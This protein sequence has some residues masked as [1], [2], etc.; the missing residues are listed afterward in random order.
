MFLTKGAC[1]GPRRSP[2]TLYCWMTHRTGTPQAASSG[3]SPATEEEGRGRAHT[4]SRGRGGPGPHGG[5][6]GALPRARSS[7]AGGP[8]RPRQWREPRAPPLS[9][10]PVGP[11]AGR[12]RAVSCCPET[13]PTWPVSAAT[14]A[15]S[16]CSW[17][18]PGV[19]WAQP[20]EGPPLPRKCTGGIDPTGH[21]GLALN[22]PPQHAVSFLPSAKTGP[23]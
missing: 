13:G 4:V 20:P 12:P 9:T 15:A 10:A 7:G 11:E 3:P 22:L 21:L 16:P 17:T 18:S 5:G 8:G 1:G 23:L 19:R 6:S 2:F 14:P